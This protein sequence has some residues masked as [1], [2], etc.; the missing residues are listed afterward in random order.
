MR[1]VRDCEGIG[2]ETI[3]MITDILSEDDISLDL[4]TK[5]K[6]SALSK[7][8]ARI[9]TRSRIDEKR[10]LAGLLRREWLGSTGIGRGVA[11]PHALLD[12]I[13]SPV[14]TLTRLAKPIDF[15]SPDDDPVD[16]LFTLLWPRSKVRSFLPSLAVTW[17]TL[18]PAL[19]RV[20]L[21]EAQ[22]V[23]EVMAILSAEAEPIVGKHHMAAGVLPVGTRFSNR[24]IQIGP[25]AR[26]T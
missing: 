9:A 7:I 23:D 2:M 1:F 6:R 10:V 26:I 8:A 13:S 3:M 4:V 20:R 12:D 18:R 16:L 25:M 19:I 11:I 15:G 14:A 22:S 5:G 21:R 17:R 24:A